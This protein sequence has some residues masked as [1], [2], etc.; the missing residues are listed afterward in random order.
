MPASTSRASS[1]AAIV[2]LPDAGRPVNHSVVPFAPSACQRSSRVRRPSSQTTFDVFGAG[3]R[4]I[5]AATVSFVASS[6]RM[7]LPV[8]RLRRYGSNASGTAVRIVMRPMS[9]SSSR[10]TSSSRCSVSTSM[11]CSRSLTTARVV[12][13]VCLTR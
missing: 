9:L 7:K 4:S 3:P 2:D 1:A 6:M 13:V 11:R 8:A 12:R 10:S 5:P